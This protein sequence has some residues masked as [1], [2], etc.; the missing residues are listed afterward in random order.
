M[1][2]RVYDF[3]VTLFGWI[4]L[5]QIPTPWGFHFR[6]FPGGCFLHVGFVTVD[7]VRDPPAAWVIEDLENELIDTQDRAA[8]GLQLASCIAGLEYWVRQ[9]ETRAVAFERE[10]LRWSAFDFTKQTAPLVQGD[11]PIELCYLLTASSALATPIPSPRSAT[12]TAR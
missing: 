9:G 2:Y 8:D 6:R 1:A 10:T 7:I 12:A 3:T 4:C 5:V 11:N